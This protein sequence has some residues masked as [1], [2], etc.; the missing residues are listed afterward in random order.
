MVMS[1]TKELT[2]QERALQLSLSGMTNKDI[3]DELGVSEATASR[4]V[5]DQRASELE[6]L[7]R[8]LQNMK[9]VFTQMKGERDGLQASFMA[10][11]ED[12]EHMKEAFTQMKEERDRLQASFTAV[13]EEADG[14]K[15]AFTQMKEERDHLQA[16][17][18]AV[19]EDAERVKVLES[20]LKETES[21]LQAITQAHEST[22]TELSALRQEVAELSGARQHLANAQAQ[23]KQLRE[24]EEA[25]KRNWFINLFKGE[26][27]MTLI[28]LI[29]GVSVAA[30][31]TAPIFMTVGVPTY[32][33]YALAIFVDIAAFIFILNNRHRLGVVFSF[34]T[35]MQALIKLGGLH[36]MEDGTLI[37]VKAAV[38][39]LSLGI[40]TYGFSDLIA[41]NKK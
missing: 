17:F 5:N 31:I 3:A 33:A 15:E 1:K 20:D 30:A 8:E 19:K 39:A 6:V 35:A 27:F 37:V 14:M 32:L 9:G 24:A 22:C 11:K 29:G 16:S 2:N 18:T 25:R 34:A 13:K 10:V 7:S 21:A 38:L 28:V 40:A 12:A 26:G 36:W 41:H 4:W 23:L